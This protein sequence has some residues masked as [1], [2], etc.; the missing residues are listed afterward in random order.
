MTETTAEGR[1]W[2]G[3]LKTGLSRSSSRLVEGIA[4]ALTSGKL[5]E[6]TLERLE[7]LLVG[8]DLGPRTAAALVAALKA[9]RFDRGVTADDVRAALAGEIATR[10]APAARPLVLDPAR[11]PFVVLVVGANGGGKTTTVGKLASLFGADGK[12]VVLAAGDTFR[13]AAVSQLR[14]WGD[15]VGCPVIVGPEG[16]DPASLAYD[17]LEEA[18]RRDADLLLIDTAGRLHNK[19]GLM[20]ELQKIVRALRKADPTAPHECLLILDAT[21]GQNALAQV[22]TFRTMVDVSGLVLTKLDGSARG[23][24]LVALAEKFSL[25]VRAIGVGEGAKDFRQFD[26]VEF[27]GGLLSEPL[28]PQDV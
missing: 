17:A 26:A 3:R 6:A 25:P 1:G 10:L 18:R 5:D 2:L 20:A 8:A 28:Q 12:Q 13:A 27:A 9:R 16:G 23:G 4:S 15:R 19:A 22:E 11:R 21:I 7:E 24:I 14:L